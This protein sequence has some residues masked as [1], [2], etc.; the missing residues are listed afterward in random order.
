MTNKEKLADT[1]YER[2]IT[3]INKTNHLSDKDLRLMYERVIEDLKDM[4]YEDGEPA[5]YEDDL[6]RIKIAWNR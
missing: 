1:S 4:F 2:V 5:I 6:V 3:F